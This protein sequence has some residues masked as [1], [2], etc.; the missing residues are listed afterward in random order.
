MKNLRFS[1]RGLFV[2][3]AIIG[4]VVG[5]LQI[6]LNGLANSVTIQ[7]QSGQDIEWL[8]VSIGSFVVFWHDVPDGQQR[9]A[10]FS[11]SGDH[12]FLI[13]GRLADGTLFQDAQGYVT[14]GMYGVRANIAVQPRGSI[15]FWQEQ[16]FP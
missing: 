2:S 7:N 6:A 9:L 5:L 15:D 16:R 4:A 14:G 12:H 10:N 13:E 3:V 11:A 8:S 1:L